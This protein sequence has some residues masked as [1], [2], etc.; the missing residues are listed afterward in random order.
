[1]KYIERENILV[2]TMAGREQK[3][4]TEWRKSEI[5]SMRIYYQDF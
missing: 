3:Q 5:R 2:Q 4:D 1:M